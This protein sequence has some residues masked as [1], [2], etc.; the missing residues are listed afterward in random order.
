VLVDK[1]RPD[2]GRV[3]IDAFKW[4]AGKL[5]GNYSD[6]L[7]TENLNRNINTD[8]DEVSTEELLKIATEKTKLSK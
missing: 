5:N 7:F 8:V 4:T 1:Y 6:K 3:A 2:Q